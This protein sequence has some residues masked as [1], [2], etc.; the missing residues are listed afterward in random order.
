VVTW[1]DALGHPLD[2]FHPFLDLF[3]P[4][5]PGLEPGLGHC[6]VGGVHSR[7]AI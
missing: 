6:L 4:F 7:I 5:E 3:R 1:I 2:F